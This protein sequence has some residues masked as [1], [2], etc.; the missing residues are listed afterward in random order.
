MRGMGEGRACPGSRGGKK[1]LDGLCLAAVCAAG[2]GAQPAPVLP[3]PA[4]LPR[5]VEAA[6]APM[7][8]DEAPPQQAQQAQ[9]AQQQVQPVKAE[10]GAGVGAKSFYGGGGGGATA[11]PSGSAPSALSALNALGRAGPGAGAAAAAAAPGRAPPGGTQ[12]W[13]E[14]WRP[15]TTQEL[16]GAS[17]H[18]WAP[19]CTLSGA[20]WSEGRRHPPAG[21]HF[22]CNQQHTLAAH[23]R[24]LGWAL[25]EQE[26][27]VKKGGPRG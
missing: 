17:V 5:L 27:C 4:P 16:V 20:A 15:K 8:E 26:E 2:A 7:E 6:P 12:L 24:A 19:G 9:Q 13:V 10:P 3:P 22:P 25:A 21:A 23:A 18:F 11:G 1:R 14:K